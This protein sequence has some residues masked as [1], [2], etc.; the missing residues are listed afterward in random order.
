MKAGVAV[1][2]AVLMLLCWRGASENKHY[3]DQYA[4]IKL[5]CSSRCLAK[6]YFQDVCTKVCM[7]SHC[8]HHVYMQE[9]STFTLELG[10]N[11][12]REQNFR[13]CWMGQQQ[14]QQPQ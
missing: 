11:D 8:N 12:P 5:N 2:L 4:K 13:K 6:G 9:D 7:S 1:L 10:V 3:S 14:T